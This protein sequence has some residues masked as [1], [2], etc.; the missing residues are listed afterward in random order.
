M[1][2]ADESIPRTRS[3]RCLSRGS[4]SIKAQGR[5]AG[6]RCCCWELGRLLPGRDVRAFVTGGSWMS[7]YRETATR[8]I[9]WLGSAFNLK[10]INSRASGR[11][12][13]AEEVP[14][15]AW[16]KLTRG[17]LGWHSV[18]HVFCK[19]AAIY[20]FGAVLT[21]L[22]TY[23]LASLLTGCFSL[24][25]ILFIYLYKKRALNHFSLPQS[26]N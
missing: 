15:C 10:M 25:F 7:K 5:H 13:D 4:G 8:C 11:L 17:I 3:K 14:R 12:C 2:P 24:A 1:L 21:G 9:G 26:I 20:A 23:L 16:F 6:S 22:V 18:F 19:E